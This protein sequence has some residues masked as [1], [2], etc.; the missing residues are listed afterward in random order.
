[1]HFPSQIVH[2]QE[3]QSQLDQDIEENQ[4]ERNQKYRELRKREE[5]MDS[6]LASFEEGKSQELERLATLEQG[7][8]TLTEEMSRDLSR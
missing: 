5:N 1:M 8:Q 7:I 6:F 4:S 3:E 2:L